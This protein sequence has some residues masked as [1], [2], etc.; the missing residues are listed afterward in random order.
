VRQTGAGPSDH[1]GVAGTGR[2]P[3][4]ADFALQGYFHAPRLDPRPAPPP[5]LPRC[6]RAGG[7]RVS[8]V[9]AA[10]SNEAAKVRMLMM[11]MMLVLLVLLL[12]VLTLFP[13]PSRC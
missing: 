6:S 13:A 10:R 8:L 1:V 12:L 5:C 3:N 4:A 11:M 2:C 7:L 9:D